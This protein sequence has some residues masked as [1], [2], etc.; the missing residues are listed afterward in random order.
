MSAPFAASGRRKPDKGLVST[1]SKA[2]NIMT[3]G[4]A[5][6]H[7][8]RKLYNGREI[9]YIGNNGATALSITAVVGATSYEVGSGGYEGVKFRSTVRDYLI[10]AADLAPL[11]SGPEVGDIIEDAGER[12]ELVD[13]GDGQGAFTW[14]DESRAVYRVH[15]RCLT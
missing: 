12:Y 1:M 8:Q 14:S 13:L 5:W 15:V 11:P 9:T 10:E 4:L 2:F 3:S 6:M 7:A